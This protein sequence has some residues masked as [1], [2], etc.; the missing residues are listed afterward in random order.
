M[1]GTPRVDGCCFNA[2]WTMFQQY[3]DKNK[4]HF[5]DPELTMSLFLLLHT[6]NN[7]YMYQ[8]YS[9]LFDLTGVKPTTYRAREKHDNYYIIELLETHENKN[10]VMTTGQL[11]SIWI[12]DQLSE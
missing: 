11:M 3:H 4:L 7:K 12:N 6:R 1:L 10:N 9:L 5:P 2:K 8:C